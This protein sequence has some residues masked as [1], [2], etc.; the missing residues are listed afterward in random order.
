M[1]PSDTRLPSSGKEAAPAVFASDEFYRALTAAPRRRILFHLLEHEQSTIEELAD[2]LYGWELR[3]D[4]H[5][6]YDGVRAQ[7]YHTH[8]PRLAA[9]D[10]VAFD[11]ETGHVECLDVPEAVRI[12]VHKSIAAE[13]RDSS[14]TE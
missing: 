10:L 14:D 8:L 1:T 2:L 4:E 3:T 9:S 6:T 13:T 5:S 7:L 12:L 11:S